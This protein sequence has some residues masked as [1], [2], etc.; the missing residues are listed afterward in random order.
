MTTRELP[1]EAGHVLCPE[2]GDVGLEQCFTCRRFRRV[3]CEGERGE[4]QAVECRPTRT[5]LVATWS[6][7]ADVIGHLPG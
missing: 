2:S 7:Y 4:V 6:G 5:G 1:V 3:V